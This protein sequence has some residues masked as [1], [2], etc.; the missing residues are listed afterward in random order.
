MKI[1]IEQDT[2]PESPRE[3]SNL[4]T[5]ACWHGRY[6]LGDEQPKVDPQEWLLQL[7]D[8]FE[9]GILDRVERYAERA[10]ARITRL[11]LT[12]LELELEEHA[13]AVAGYRDRVVGQCLDRHVIMLPLYLYDH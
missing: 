12:S 4:G 11:G 1:R 13:K 9:P 8:E 7:A 10:W 6:N 5:M 2:T 3:W